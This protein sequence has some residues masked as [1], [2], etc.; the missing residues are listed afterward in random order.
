MDKAYLPSSHK[1]FVVFTIWTI[2]S[3]TYLVSSCFARLP[4]PALWPWWGHV[5]PASNQ[6]I[7]PSLL[8]DSFQRVEIFSPWPSF[9]CFLFP[10]YLIDLK[11]L[12]S[13]HVGFPLGKTAWKPIPL[14]LNHSRWDAW[15][16]KDSTHLEPC[17]PPHRTSQ[18]L[19]LEIKFL[20]SFLP[21]LHIIHHSNFFLMASPSQLQLIHF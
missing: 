11:A 6:Q 8:A 20:Q 13:F 15:A 10:A 7:Q 14:L 9:Q 5:L 12:P 2:I 3:R 18:K 1:L 4:D 19:C 17:L 21:G 16:G